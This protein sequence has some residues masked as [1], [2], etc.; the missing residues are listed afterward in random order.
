[1]LYGRCVMPFVDV[2]GVV[3]LNIPEVN[4]RVAGVAAKINGKISHE[5][6]ESAE[7][8]AGFGQGFR[9]P[10]SVPNK[11]VHFGRI[12]ACR[13]VLICFVICF[14]SLLYGLLL[15]YFVS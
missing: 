1:M 11:C 4:G 10:S 8:R 13:A 12:I 2:P 5:V 3:A 15:C 14:H 7:P 6:F 9:K